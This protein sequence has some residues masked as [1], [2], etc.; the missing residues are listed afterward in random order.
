MPHGFRF[1]ES[2]LC[3]AY[4]AVIAFWCLGQE[5]N[6]RR[7][8]NQSLALPTELPRRITRRIL[9]LISVGN[10]S[11]PRL[12][13][14]SLFAVRA[15]NKLDSSFY[16]T[17]LNMYIFKTQKNRKHCCL[18]LKRNTNYKAYG[19]SKLTLSNELL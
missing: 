13:R 3:G 16:K 11:I 12:F 17:H 4:F 15:F 19:I 1:I 18:C 5:S 6:L 14:I 9:T 8:D 2:L 7:R 10:L